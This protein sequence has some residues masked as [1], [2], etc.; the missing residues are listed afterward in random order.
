MNEDVNSINQYKKTDSKEID[1][2]PANEKGGPSIETPSNT[3]PESAGEM[4]IE[5]YLVY[6]HYRNPITNESFMCMKENTLEPYPSWCID[7]GAPVSTDAIKS[8]FYDLEEKLGFQHDNT[9]NMFDHLMTQLD[10]RSSRMPCSSAL[11]SLHSDYIGGPQSNYKKWYFMAHIELD[12]NVNDLKIWNKYGKTYKSTTSDIDDKTTL[13]GLDHWWHQKMSQLSDIQYIIHLSLYLLIWGEANNVR[14]IPEAICFIFKCSLDY[15]DY[16]TGKQPEFQNLTKVPKFLESVITPLYKFIRNQQYKLVDGKWIRNSKD[17]DSIIGYDDIN[18]FF[19]YPENLIKIRLLDTHKTL[20]DYPKH[21]RLLHFNRINWNAIFYKTYRE[22]RSWGHLLTNFSRVWIIHISIFWYY[23][24]F[25]SPALYTKGYNQLLNNPPAPQIQ[26]TIVS[27][28]GA[29][30]CLISFFAT[31]LEFQYVPRKFPG[32]QNVFSRLIILIVLTIINVGPSIYILGFIPHDAYSIHGTYLGIGQFVIS[33]LT[34]LL[35]A[36]IPPANLGPKTS[37]GIKLQILTASFPKLSLR[38]QISSIILWILVFFFKFFESYVFLTLSLRDP[39]RVLWIMDLSRCGGDVIFQQWICKYQAKCLLGLLYITDLVL[40]FLDT[41]LWYVIINCLFSIGLSFSLGISVFTPWRNIFARLPERIFSKLLYMRK[42]GPNNGVTPVVAQVWNSIIISMYR[43]HL[44]SLEQVN[45]LVYQFLEPDNEDHPRYNEDGYGRVFIKPPLFF[46]FQDDNAFHL[47][48]FFMPGKDA[49]RRIS[50][51]A[52]SLSSPI[53]EPIP[54]TS[55]PSFTVLIP[56]YSETILLTLRELLRES[57]HSKVSVLDYL[58]QLN[59]SD[60]ESFV[61]DSKILKSFSSQPQLDNSGEYK[62]PDTADTFNNHENNNKSAVLDEQYEDLPYYYLGFKNSLPEYTLRTRIWCSLRLQTLYRTVSGF[63]NYE[64]A[65][66]M[67]YRLE[68]GDD[69]SKSLLYP[70]EFELE[71]EAFATR[72]FKLLLSLQRFQRFNQEE[73]KSIDLLFETFPSVNVCYLEEELDETTNEMVYY[74][75]LLDVSSKVNDGNNNSNGNGN[76]RTTYKTR[77]RIRL[78]GNPIMGDGKSDNQ[79]HAIIFYR[80]EYIQVIDANQDNYLE[81]CLKIKSIL[82]EFEEYKLDPS[83][84][85]NYGAINNKKEPVAIVGA[86]EYIFSENIGVLGDIAAAK[87]QTFGTLFARTLAEIGGKLHYGHP[88]FLNGI[89]MNTRGGVSK[90]QKG[91]HL[92]EDIYAGMMATC[93]GG[94]IKHCDYYQCGKGRDLGFNTILN[95]T[96]KIGAGMGEQILS[97]EHYYLGTNLPLDRFLSFYYAHA[98]F[99]INNL[100]ISLSA[101]LFMM[102]LIQLSSLKNETIL[103]SYNPDKPI[104]D[105]LEPLGCYNIEPVLHWVSRFVLS[106]FIC[107]FISFLPLLFQELIEKGVGKAIMR[108]IYHFISLSPLFEVFVCQVYAKSLQTNISM[109]GAKYIATGRGFATSRES[110]PVLYSRYSLLSIHK[111]SIFF[112]TVIVA[113]IIMWQ[114][115]LLWFFISFISMCLA[116][117]LFNPHQFSWRKFFLDYRELIRWFSRGNSRWHNNSWYGYQ[118]LQRIKVVGYK[119]K[120]FDMESSNEIQFKKDLN[121][122]RRVSFLHKV[123]E[124][125][126]VALFPVTFT[127]TSFMFINSQTGVAPNERK[128]VNPLIRIMVITFLPI[129]L[130]SCFLLIGFVSSI[131]LGPILF[132]NKFASIIAAITHGI[133]VFNLILTFEVLLYCESFNVSRTLIG[134]ILIIFL[135]KLLRNIVYSFLITKEIKTDLINNIWWSGK[136]LHNIRSLKSLIITQ[137][138]REFL[139]KNIEVISFSYD[140]L[141]CHFLLFSTT[142]LLLTPFIDKWH[143]LMLFWSK[144]SKQFRNPI[145]S[146]RLRSKQ[147]FKIFKYLLLYFTLLVTFVALIGLPIMA[148]KYFNIINISDLVDVPY[149]DQLIQPNGQPNNDTGPNAPASVVQHVPQYTPLPTIF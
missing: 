76:G 37:N 112:M 88:D 120:L 49:E 98:G 137:P 133:G 63:M 102:V 123:F 33:I 144:P 136:W 62:E 47:S 59:R 19:W 130:N 147:N 116:P 21:E 26:W 128:P 43:E 115:S 1:D 60:W 69:N 51:F 41:Y 4:G 71:L 5:D 100:F 57:K 42:N 34:V 52:Q 55:M 50:F 111:G 141:L 28:G 125:V 80:G 70:D 85:Y 83:N 118:K 148:N 16:I 44:L 114:V 75:T 138:F 45:K 126:C 30:A 146:K 15:Y 12:E 65:I 106:V 61:Q 29:I 105:L 139:I 99:H 6:Q 96:I 117:L 84:D 129:L 40:F 9:E 94:R 132:F 64:K 82:S 67:L 81:E 10:S 8:I 53:A 78:S 72:K 31:I 108:I 142:P 66:K 110:F 14:F 91:L 54:T 134:I 7:N 38:A 121:N 143:T 127:L 89:F 79:N 109:G 39:I 122:R 119:K 22:K 77:Y 25:N 35:L 3:A 131:L 17:H 23:T 46:V 87:E 20:L 92:N 27:L 74:S 103:C 36:I 113:S 24:S 86:R 124:Q 48:D 58:K 95:F 90:A 32:S 56:H 11:L 107:F 73:Q 93:R 149:L 140:F 145:I 97:R 18:Q 2:E 135:H 101:L 13:R 104:T 68:N